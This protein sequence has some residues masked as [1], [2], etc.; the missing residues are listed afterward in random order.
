[1][2]GKSPSQM[3]FSWKGLSALVTPKA[4]EKLYF[5]WSKAV[6]SWLYITSNMLQHQLNS[7]WNWMGPQLFQLRSS[8]RTSLSTRH[9]LMALSL[10]NRVGHLYRSPRIVFLTGMVML[11]LAISPSKSLSLIWKTRRAGWACPTDLLATKAISLSSLR[12]LT[13]F[14]LIWDLNLDLLFT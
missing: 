8:K 5:G 10:I 7:K 3:L 6:I 9:I 14:I 13:P 2:S 12:P 1:M 11:F 4:M